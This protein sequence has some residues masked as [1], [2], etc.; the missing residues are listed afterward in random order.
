MASRVVTLNRPHRLNAIQPELLE[1][2][3]AA[4]HAADR[5]PGVRAIVLTGAGRAFSAR[6]T[7]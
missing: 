4:L 6:A 5:D 3:I 7:T 1:D 2:L